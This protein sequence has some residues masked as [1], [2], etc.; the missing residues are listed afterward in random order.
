MS[1]AKIG[2]GRLLSHSPGVNRHVDHNFTS[3][4]APETPIFSSGRSAKILIFYLIFDKIFEELSS[5]HSGRGG[6]R[7]GG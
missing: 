4:H 2:G 3:K 5:R 1:I 6:S 7:K